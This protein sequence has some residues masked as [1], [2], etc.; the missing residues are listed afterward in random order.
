MLY[1]FLLNLLKTFST[2]PRASGDERDFFIYK[3]NNIFLMPGWIF[4]CMIDATHELEIWINNGSGSDMVGYIPEIRV[5][6]ALHLWFKCKYGTVQMFVFW[7]SLFN[8][9]P[10][11]LL[12]Y[13]QIQPTWYNL[14]IVAWNPI[15]GYLTHPYLNWTW[16]MISSQ[17]ILE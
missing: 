10:T 17:L 16:V 4:L 15:F 5:L 11:N 1:G 13:L 14:H 9:Y 12:V 8:I 2:I 7:N 3:F 6:L